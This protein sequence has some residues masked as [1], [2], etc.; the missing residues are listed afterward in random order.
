MGLKGYGYCKCDDVIADEVVFNIH[1]LNKTTKT[2]KK[3]KY[4]PASPYSHYIRNPERKNKNFLFFQSTS[5]FSN[6]SKITSHRV[7][8]GDFKVRT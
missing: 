4:I 5:E 8:I 6:K 7:H 2:S 3:R 1:A